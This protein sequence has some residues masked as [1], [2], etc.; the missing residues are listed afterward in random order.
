[1]KDFDFR[2]P[3]KLVFGRDTV[4]RI[5]DEMQQAGCRRALLVAGGGSIRNNGVYDT[6]AASLKSAGI[7]WNE[8]WGVQPN[9]VLSKVREGVAAATEHGSDAVLAVG[10]G[11]VIDS[12]KAIAAGVFLDDIWKAGGKR[13]T[14]AEALP[15]FTVLT[16]S[17]TGSEMNPLAVITNEAEKKKWAMTGPALYPRVSVVDPSVQVTLPWTQT[18]NGAVDAMSHTM[19]FYFTAWGSETTMAIDEA[20]LATI[21][22]AADRLQQAGDDY[23]ARADLAWAAALALSGISGAGAGSGDF[24][25]HLTEHGLSAV[26]PDVAHAVGLAILFPAWIQYMYDECP[27]IFDRWARRVW[28]AETMAE[29][30]AAM[31]AK[32]EQ[33]GHPTRLRQIGVDESEIGEIAANAAQI[34]E[35]G[36][37]RKLRE[38]DIAEVLKLAL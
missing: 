8:L 36:N 35:I 4:G 20:L 19:E 2:N 7:E 10:G 3:T 23:D 31:R 21:I 28:S 38:G 9:P 30:V 5:G 15:I 1:M 26:R 27:P 32:L 29:G 17:A 14:L 34:G 33:W 22:G 13:I 37:L 25:T 11:S 18:V 6:V 16:L 24:A 12:A